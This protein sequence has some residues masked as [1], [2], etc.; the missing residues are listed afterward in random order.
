MRSNVFTFRSTEECMT[1]PGHR[2]RKSQPAAAFRGR[3][4]RAGAGLTGAAS[5]SAAAQVD[6]AGAAVL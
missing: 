1:D 5:S 2:Q 4:R 3:P 6:S